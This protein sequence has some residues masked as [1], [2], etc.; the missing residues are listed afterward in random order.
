M[1]LF[2]SNAQQLELL[3][4]P[5][6]WPT[7]TYTGPGE[8]D[9][10]R[11]SNQNMSFRHDIWGVY[12]ATTLLP[13]PHTALLTN[14]LQIQHSQDVEHSSQ[15][16]QGFQ[17]LHFYPI[18][19]SHIG[20]IITKT[21][22]F[23]PAVSSGHTNLLVRWS[24]LNPGMIGAQ[25]CP[26]STSSTPPHKLELFSRTLESQGFDPC[27]KTFWRLLPP[28]WLIHV[29]PLH[30]RALPLWMDWLRPT[31]CIWHLTLSSDSHYVAPG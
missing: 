21:F 15:W 20:P 14:L 28:T 13:V 10:Q 7:Y 22:L 5:A 25:W 16:A 29:Q 3:K 8:T 30:L 19:C 23:I 26:W 4:R 11:D 2:I 1:S 9:L 12:T 31:N 17:Q 24:A 18:S 27:E 6:S